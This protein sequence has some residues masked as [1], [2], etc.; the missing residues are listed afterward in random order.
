M[1]AAIH[2]NCRA[3]LYLFYGLKLKCAGLFQATLRHIPAFVASTLLTPSKY[4]QL[5]GERPRLH[6]N[7]NKTSTFGKKIKKIKKIG[8]G[9]CLFFQTNLG[10]G[11][12]H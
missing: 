2:K 3:A 7:I 1:N 9:G 4:T 12:E 6:G 10:A 8:A 11:T 5:V